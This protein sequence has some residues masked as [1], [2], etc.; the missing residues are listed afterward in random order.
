M[1]EPGS[2][3]RD[4]KAPET[5]TQPAFDPDRLAHLEVAGWRAYYDKAW[6][7]MLR[8][9]VQLTHEQFGLTWPR[10]I[11]GAYYVLRASVAW[12]PVEHDLRIVRRHLRKFYTLAHRRGKSSDFDPKVVA[13]KELR[14]WIVSR[15][16]SSTPW[17]DD[18]PIIGTMSDLHAALFNITPDAARQSGWGRARSLHVVGTITSGRSGDPEGDWEIAERYLRE[19]YRRLLSEL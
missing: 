9:L 10:S 7:K 13:D 16:Y 1:V 15:K 6:L 8:L 18:S 3:R 5:I 19:G 2:D 12:K 11:Q 4:D 14:Y 17:R